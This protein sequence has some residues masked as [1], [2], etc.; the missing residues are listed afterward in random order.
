MKPCKLK[1]HLE[2]KHPTLKDKSLNCF[3]IKLSGLE[4]KKRNLSKH[5]SV[6][7]RFLDASYYISKRVAKV[8]KPHTIAEV[9]ILPKIS[10]RSCSEIIFQIS[11]IPLSNDTVSRCISDVAS[12]VKE[13]LLANIMQGQYYALQLDEATD[14]AGLAQMLTYV[15]YVKKIVI[16]RRTFFSVSLFQSTQPA[17][18][19]LKFWMDI[20]RMQA[21]YGI[22]VLG[23]AQTGP[24][25][26]L[27]GLS[28]VSRI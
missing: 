7:N 24:V 22:N 9:L 19:C 2:T 20:Y 27:E 26:W 1:R 10:V 16:L 6:S 23:F 8:G 25:Q 13:Q 11:D 3:Y 17:R 4:Q 14:V 21:C 18:H 28:L 5:T 15:R 12:D